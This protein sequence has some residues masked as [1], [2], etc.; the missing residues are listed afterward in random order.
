MSLA[1]AT[2]LW[3]GPVSMGSSTMEDGA[4]N[5]FFQQDRMV[6]F[7][8]SG[9]TAATYRTFIRAVRNHL[10][11][12]EMQH[13]IPILPQFKNVPT[14]ERFLLIQ[15]ANFAEQTITLAMNVSN[16]YIVGYCA[17]NHAYFFPPETPEAEEEIA[18]LFPRTDREFMTG[19][20]VNYGDLERVANQNRE[21]TQL[22]FTPL[23]TAIAHLHG[24]TTNRTDNRNLA[25]GFLVI[26]QMIA[27]AAR[28]NLISTRIARSF[29]NAIVPD[30]G[31]IQ[32][33]NDWSTIST[34][35]Q[36][37]NDDGVLPEPLLL[38][39]P[40]GQ[41]IEVT[42]V[43]ELLTVISLLLYP[44][45]RPS[46]FSLLI[47]PVVPN[48]ADD[49]V[50][51]THQLTVRISGRNGL[52][53]DVKSGIYSDG[54]PVVL[55]PC[56]SNTDVNQLWT[57]RKDGTIRSD[58][59]CLTTFGFVPGKYIMIHDCKNAVRDATRWKI[60]DDGTII[61]PKSGLVLSAES[62]RDGTTITVETNVYAARQSWLP[63]N[64]TQPFI[65]TIVGLNYLC[66]QATGN[67]VWL[68]KCENNK[69]GQ[70]WALYGDGTIRPK[71]NQEDCVTNDAK[72]QGL[73]KLFS[74]NYA[75]PAQRW[76]FDSDGVIWSLFYGM[77]LDVKDN[78][79]SLKQIITSPFN[80]QDNQ[81]WL[82][83]F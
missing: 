36:Q 26:A 41:P 38:R 14:N 46:Q 80:G 15:L 10:T 67:R 71:Q 54:S 40:R 47:R 21:Q 18:P 32:L 81:R 74:Y 55:W 52:C 66:L 77:V 7:T 51:V 62:G 11:R 49:D 28:F 57:F 61:N 42:Q 63:G 37:S 29:S 23:D 64:N 48:F 2:C 45:K 19:L 68:E 82:K 76:V 34:A 27:E 60:R 79:P 59:K 70:E 73:V 83:S 22:G 69:A 5:P 20:G 53:L 3:L 72:E 35:I 30:P 56:K 9:A 31:M 1:V 8:T 25:R 65:T 6:I 78:D 24:L 43:K 44:C 58:G 50:C 75:S 16:V 17:E 12:Q 33:E 39:D 13:G 4:V